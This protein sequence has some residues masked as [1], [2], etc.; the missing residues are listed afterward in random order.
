MTEITNTCPVTGLSIVE[1]AHWTDIQVSDQYFVT[2]RMIGE[3]ILQ[4]IPRGNTAKIDV[5]KLYFH[6]DEVL[7]ESVKPGVKIAEIRDYQDVFGNP[8]PQAREAFVRHF[9]KENDRCLGFVA[10]NS[11][12]V[13][14]T[15]M[16]LLLKLLKISY[17]LETRKD[18]TGAVKRA[19]E[20]IHEFDSKT[21]LDPKYFVTND[22]WKY[23]AHGFSAE[24]KVI[25]RKVLYSTYKGY[26]QKDYVDP[27]YRIVTQIHKGDYLDHS[28]YY[29][30]SDFSQAIG[31]SWTARLKYIRLLRK[32]HAAYEP[33]KKIIIVGSNGII[34]TALK[35]LGRRLDTPMIFASDLNQAL[36][37]IRGWSF[38]SHPGAPEA[39]TGRHQRQE[40]PQQKYVDDL[41]DFI[42]SFTW[43]APGSKIKEIPE[44]HPFKLVFDA[45]NLIKLD[46]DSLL[47]ERTFAQLQLMEKEKNYRDLFQY[48][49]DAIMLADENG[50]FDCNEAAIKIFKARK[51]ENLI[52]LQPW[53]LSPPAQIDGSDSQSV[54]RGTWKKVLEE[55]VFRTEWLIKR[56]DGEVFPSEVVLSVLELG[57]K[58]I[59]QVVTRDITERKKAEAEIQKAREEAEFANNA[60][61]QFLANMS[62]EIR[63]PLN[64][65][66]GMTDLLLMSELTGEQRERLMDIKYSGQSLMDIIN[67]ILDF[68]R[69]EAG[70]ISLE[71]VPFRISEIV[72]RILRMLGVKAHEKNLALLASVDTGIPDMTAG[73]PVRI[74][75][76]LLNLID[77]AIKF[78]DKG[79][80]LLII[81][82]KSEIGQAVTVEIS[83]SD[84]G[85]GIAPDKIASLFQKFSQ[86]DAS[87]T[88]LHGG[89]GLGLAIAQSLVRLMGGNIQV[90]SSV[91]KGSRFFFEITLEKE[92]EKQGV[93]E[94]LAT[95]D[96]AREKASCPI[97]G[98]KEKLTVLLA[99]DHPINRR[100]VERFLT[101]KGWQVIHA[102]NGREAIQKFRENQGNV[103][104]ILMD[105][106]MPEVD[107]YEAA[108]RIR[109]LEAEANSGMARRVPIIALTAHALAAYQEKSYSSGM[110]AYLT[111]PIN[112]EELYH[113]VHTLTSGAQSTAP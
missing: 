24:F 8:P 42:A 7:K 90:E 77:N 58:E 20:M 99:E 64:G 96:A 91:G 35:M 30:V 12:R 45:V 69:I 37:W 15:V 66:M 33:P 51:K 1:K 67:E 52:G 9:D 68:S 14:L 79:E 110:D 65:I 88:R 44:S 40:S 50:I 83:V 2:F 3:R 21:V 106:Q 48:S 82:K 104:L 70:K 75:Q 72:Q 49:G 105:I 54:I 25:N 29:Q 11:S 102:E 4:V 86:V 10:Y 18:Y 80:V 103:D 108:A 36:T 38:S 6:R 78:T 98:N 109:Q 41:L 53:D 74:R 100:L 55:G 34:N 39:P 13:G 95:S 28:G 113:L 5:D 61:S 17:P 19:L 81:K 89:T 32:T 56:F 97:A 16:R 101:M 94:T 60:K 43:D 26:L 27:I 59:I 22:E 93:T 73:D 47:K 71:H 87:T 84:T 46:I 112:P 63:T 62:H 111:K 85:V 57:G 76:V 23:N 92:I 107:G 31:G